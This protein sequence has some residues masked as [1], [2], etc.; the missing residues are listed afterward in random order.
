MVSV[1]LGKRRISVRISGIYNSD[2]GINIV[3]NTILDYFPRCEYGY[4]KEGW[5]YPPLS[6]AWAK[7]S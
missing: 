1:E 2:V 5:V 6:I 4:S 7:T 3:P